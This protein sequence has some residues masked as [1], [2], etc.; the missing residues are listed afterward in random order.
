MEK[1]L[2]KDLALGYT[3]YGV[4]RDDIKVEI[5]GIDVRT[6]GSQG[7]QRTCAL[8]LKLA[9]L[10]IIRSHT[11]STPVLILDDVLSELDN[12]RQKKLLN[13][14]Q[15]AQTLISCTNFDF[16]I[17]HKK[18]II[19]NG[20]I[21]WLTMPDFDVNIIQK[22]RWKHESKWNNSMEKRA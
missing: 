14:C 9:E 5:N 1:N 12:T 11:R 10:E 16:K 15:K 4:H 22:E 19:E 8:S 17:N 20:K 18:I 3:S 2:E 13:F 21:R 7:Q 6:F